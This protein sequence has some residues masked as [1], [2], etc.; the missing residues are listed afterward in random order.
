MPSQFLSWYSIVSILLP[1]FIKILINGIIVLALTGYTSN[2]P[3]LPKIYTLKIQS[4]T[5]LFANATVSETRLGYF[6][7]TTKFSLE[8]C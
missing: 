6:G 8:I 2:S 3:A 7:K 5:G 4:K 1:L